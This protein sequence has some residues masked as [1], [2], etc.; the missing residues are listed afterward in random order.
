MKLK[1]S[2]LYSWLIRTLTFFLPNI[3][4]LMR[5]RGFLYSVMMKECGK[6]FQVTSSAIINSLSGLIIKNHVYIGPNTVIIGVDIIIEDEVLIGPNCVIS[7]GNHSFLNGSFRFAPSI[8]AP[9]LIK[10]GSWIAANCTITA[11]AVMPHRSILA[12]GAV[13]SQKFTDGDALYGGIPAKFIKT[14]NT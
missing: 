2:I 14:I 8:G 10:K 5:F 9:V 7:G 4:F 1:F 3:P 11:G 6:D 13:L 12:A